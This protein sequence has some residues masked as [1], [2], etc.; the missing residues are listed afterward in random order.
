MK[1]N[2]KSSV[3][4]AE[5]P[6]AFAEKLAATA[7][8]DERTAEATVAAAEE[9]TVEIAEGSS[10]KEAAGSLLLLMS[11]AVMAA[12]VVGEDGSSSVVEL[13]VGPISVDVR[14]GAMVVG[15][16][17]EMKGRGVGMYKC[18]F[19]SERIATTIREPRMTMNGRL[20]HHLPHF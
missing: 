4:L 2:R 19:H 17:F 16:Y 10:T 1:W 13:S 6:A 15:C 3:R 7:D 9:A 11:A 18:I 14:V 5:I 8:T 20:A 12:A